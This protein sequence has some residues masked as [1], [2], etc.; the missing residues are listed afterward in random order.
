MEISLR[1]YKS[2]SILAFGFVTEFFY[3]SRRPG[4]GAARGDSSKVV[5][6]APSY[7]LYLQQLEYSILIQFFFIVFMFEL[8]ILSKCVAEF[9]YNL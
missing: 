2:F 8:C 5:F 4:G 9:C 1:L 3:W 7:R 6:V